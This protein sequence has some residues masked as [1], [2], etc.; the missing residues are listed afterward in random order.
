TFEHAR[1]DR[2]DHLNRERLLGVVRQ[3]DDRAQVDTVRGVFLDYFGPVELVFEV[4]DALLDPGLLGL[5]VFQPG[6]VVIIRGAG[7]LLQ[8]PRGLV[9][10]LALLLE[11]RL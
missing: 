3:R 9:E 11:R 5:G 10:T 2:R 6:I 1:L 7:E 4:V 8:Y